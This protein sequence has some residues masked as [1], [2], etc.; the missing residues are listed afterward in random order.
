MA[1]R[2]GNAKG[3]AQHPPNPLDATH[4][5][6][7]LLLLLLFLLGCGLCAVL[8]FVRYAACRLSFVA[9]T[10]ACFLWSVVCGVRCWRWLYLYHYTAVLSVQ[11]IENTDY[12]SKIQDPRSNPQIP[13]PNLPAPYLAWPVIPHHPRSPTSKQ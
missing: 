13:N 10:V 4:R 5:R 11:F 7:R 6:V 1:G 9:L 2:G 12:R 8:C 3:S